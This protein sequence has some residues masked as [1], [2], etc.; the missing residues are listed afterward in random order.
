LVTGA[1]VVGVDAVGVGA[2]DGAEAFWKL[3]VLD[4]AFE[5][6]LAAAGAGDGATP[7][8]KLAVLDPAFGVT[9]GVGVLLPLSLLLP[10]PSLPL[11]PSGPEAF[12]SAK[13]GLTFVGLALDP[14]EVPAYLTSLLL[15]AHFVP[16]ILTKM[17]CVFF[18]QCSEGRPGM[19][20]GTTALAT[21]FSGS[22]VNMLCGGFVKMLGS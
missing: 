21:L 2:G 5:V 9:F 10:L 14:A 17:P 20:W 13:P 15:F 12:L 8:W 22:I 3:V 19:L 7:F 18:G 11:P 4:P 6:V 1:A 16:G